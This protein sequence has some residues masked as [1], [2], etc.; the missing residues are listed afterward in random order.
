MRKI[1]GLLFFIV[2]A[3]IGFIVSGNV[4]LRLTSITLEEAGVGYA[5]FVGTLTWIAVMFGASQITGRF[6]WK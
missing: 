6:V 2:A 3:C 5:T 4:G 1:L